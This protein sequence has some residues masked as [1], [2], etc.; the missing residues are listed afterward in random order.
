[1]KLS[2][3]SLIALCLVASTT[4]VAADNGMKGKMLASASEAFGTLDRNGDHRISRSEAGFDRTLSTI[5][6]DIDTDGDGYIT[7]AEYA[8]AEQHFTTMNDVKR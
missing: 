3:A 2:S 8:A 5:F 6:A 7:P 1:M 4:V